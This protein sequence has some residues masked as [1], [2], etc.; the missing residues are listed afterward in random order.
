MEKWTAETEQ[1]LEDYLA[2]VEHC[3]LNKGDEA[4]EIVSSLREHIINETEEIAGEVVTLDH[5]R[6][7]LAAVG[8][9]ESVIGVEE[10]SSGEAEDEIDPA[11]VT[12]PPPMGKQDLAKRPRTLSVGC[13]VVAIILGAPVAL[14]L[15]AIIV[16]L[17]FRVSSQADV[18]KMSLLQNTRNGLHS[19]ANLEEKFKAAKVRDDNDDGIG[20]YGSLVELN[21]FDL[22]TVDSATRRSAYAF[23]IRVSP[24]TDSTEPGFLITAAPTWL[25]LDEDL[26]V[27]TID[28]TG[29]ITDSQMGPTAKAIP[30]PPQKSV[31]SRTIADLNL[32]ARA[33]E[34]FRRGIFLDKNED[35]EGD[36]GTLKQL[37]SS[38]ANLLSAEFIP[39][40]P[41]HGGMVVYQY[42]FS[43]VVAAG[44][45]DEEPSFFCIATPRSASMGFRSFFVDQTGVIRYAEDGA[46]IGED[47]AVLYSTDQG[48]IEALDFED[49]P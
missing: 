39:G 37:A 12:F 48:E 36:Y 20:D 32:I 38:P 4:A 7:I 31:E 42:D 3:A 9:P 8:T 23:T 1:A 41:M 29:E 47:S 15:L 14:F 16:L 17:T 5:L 13:V 18:S 45:A 40:N 10:K 2:E 49:V 26:P 34:A 46:P 24:G 6:R 19:L 11:P 44:T 33:Q 30:S 21:E 27:L 43:M 28:Q 25:D 22:S 35:R